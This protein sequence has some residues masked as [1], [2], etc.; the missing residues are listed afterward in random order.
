MGDLNS[1]QDI[2]LNVES[3]FRIYRKNDEDL[4]LEL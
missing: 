3:D 4:V 1:Q 2:D